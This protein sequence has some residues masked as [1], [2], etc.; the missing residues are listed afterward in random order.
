MIPE[1]TMLT[2]LKYKK[3]KVIPHTKHDHVCT[4][5]DNQFHASLRNKINATSCKRFS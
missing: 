4:Q 3:I 5:I 1:C 2:S